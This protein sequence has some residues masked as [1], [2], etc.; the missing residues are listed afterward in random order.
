MGDGS[1]F[2]LESKKEISVLFKHSMSLTIS[3]HCLVSHRELVDKSTVKNI[4]F[5]EVIKMFRFLP[6]YQ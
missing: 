2:N 1:S 5:S 4:Y 6:M 3:I